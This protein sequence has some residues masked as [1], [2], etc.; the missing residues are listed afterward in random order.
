MP[1]NVT[2]TLNPFSGCTSGLTKWIEENEGVANRDIHGIPTS[3]ESI[4]SAQHKFQLK[5]YG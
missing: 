1:S 4:A 5:I 3:V 2:A